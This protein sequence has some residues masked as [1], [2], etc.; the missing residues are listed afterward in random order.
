MESDLHLAGGIAPSRTLH[1]LGH[2]EYAIR[3]ALREGRAIRPRRS[4]IALPGCDPELIAAAERGVVLSCITQARRLQLWVPE[5][6]EPHV[7]VRSRADRGVLRGGVVHWSAPIVPRHPS[8]LSDPIEN[9]LHYVAVC[10]PYEHALAIWESALNARLVDLDRLAAL[11]L[12]PAAR[13][14]L[15]DCTPFADS[16]L[17]TLFRIRLRWL[18]VPIRSQ[19]WLHGHRVDFLIGDR[20]VVQIDG[21][22]HSG[23]Q[24]AEDDRH[25]AELRLRG[26]SVLRFTY[27]QVMH[28]WPMVQEQIQR[29]VAVGLHRSSV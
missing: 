21:A 11:R 3:R 17:E 29:A 28:Q 22:H 6:G 4:W 12:R 5:E 10:Q 13:R 8:V 26:Y 25:D 20:L 15:A 7:A 27:A 16:G 24:R 18:R 14:V 2:S 1:E 19:I 9:A 23:A